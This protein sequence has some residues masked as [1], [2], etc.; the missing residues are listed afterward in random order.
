MEKECIVCGRPA[1]IHHCVFKSQAKYLEYVSVNL[2]PLCPEHHRGMKSPHMNKK[3]DLAYKREYQAKIEKLINQ[4]YY[5]LKE[6]QDILGIS[7]KEAERVLNKCL[8]YKEG[9]KREDIIK[10]LL[11]GRYYDK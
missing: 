7:K 10:R 9:Y 2:I 6:L 5:S 3:I 11:G 8:L 4:T 1:E